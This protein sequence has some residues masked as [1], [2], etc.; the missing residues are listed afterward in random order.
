MRYDF[1]CSDCGVTTEVSIPLAERD[2]PRPCPECGGESLYDFCST[3][4]GRKVFYE[5]NLEQFMEKLG[6][7]PP[8]LRGPEGKCRDGAANRFPGD[9]RERNR[10]L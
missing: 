1:T 7:S 2:S 3:M 8:G 4:S 10:W 6:F 5:E 9:P